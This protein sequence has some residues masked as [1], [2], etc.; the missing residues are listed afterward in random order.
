ME[1]IAAPGFSAEFRDISPDKI[2]GDIPVVYSE[3][4]SCIVA[5]SAMSP[6]TNIKLPNFP[7]SCKRSFFK[8]TS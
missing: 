8:F 3:N 6:L 2:I 4:T 5:L 7:N 1:C